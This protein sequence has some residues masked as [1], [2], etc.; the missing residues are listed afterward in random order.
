MAI[1]TIVYNKFKLNGANPNTLDGH[2]LKVTLHT[3]S[4]VPDIDAD[5]F[6]SDLTDEIAGSGGYTTGGATIGSLA[7]GIDT[8]GDFAYL[9]GNDAFW[10]GLTPSAAFRYGVVRDVTDS[11]RLILLID[12]GGDIDPAGTDYAITWPPATSGGIL[13]AE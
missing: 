12:L 11:D 1:T 6:L 13:K 7:S 4:Y 2:T 8:S 5:E 3:S 9:D 10:T